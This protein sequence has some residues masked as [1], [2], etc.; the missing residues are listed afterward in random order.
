MWCM[1]LHTKNVN[2]RPKI[3]IGLFAVGQPT[4]QNFYCSCDNNKNFPFCICG[5]SGFVLFW[6]DPYFI[7]TGTCSRF[8]EVVV[9][10]VQ[11]SGKSIEMIRINHIY[12]AP[13]HRHLL[14]SMGDPFLPLPFTLWKKEG[15]RC[16]PPPLIETSACAPIS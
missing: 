7:V 4:L 8:S 1:L 9:Y 2:V 3:K 15:V 12:M 14:L 5:K 11:L 10:S 16:P 13:I 6:F